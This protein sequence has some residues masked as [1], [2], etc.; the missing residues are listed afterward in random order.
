[1]SVSVPHLETHLE[2]LVGDRNPFSN[3]QG[4]SRAGDYIFNCLQAWGGSPW[5]EPVAMEEAVSFNVCLEIPGSH[6]GPEVVLVGAH[7][8]TVPESPGAD[9]NASAVAALLELARCLHSRGPRRTVHLIAFAL[10]EYG[11]YGSQ[12]AAS[13][14]AGAGTALAGMVSLEML[15]YTDPAPGSQKYPA[16]I[17]PGPYPVSG[18]FIAVVGNLDSAVFTQAV[19]AGLRAAAPG[20][21]VECLQVPGRGEVVPDVR[22]SD[23]VPFWDLGLPAVMLTDTANFRNPHYH[24]PTDTLETLDLEFLRDVTQG[25]LGFLRVGDAGLV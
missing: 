23:H 8:D 20:L 1:M 2:A 10:E 24:Q 11:F 17:D 19:V 7:Y 4:M 18:D 22:R 9:D 15:G 3:P 25:L 12:A 21:G 16:G 5:R 13:R 14:F 6:P